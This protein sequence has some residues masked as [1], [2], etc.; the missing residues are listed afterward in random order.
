MGADEPTQ[1]RV[2]DLIPFDFATFQ[3]GSPP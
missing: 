2:A 1:K 3:I